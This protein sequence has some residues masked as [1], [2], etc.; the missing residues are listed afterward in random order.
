M[1]TTGNIIGN[2]ISTLSQTAFNSLNPYNQIKLAGTTI[3]GIASTA[4]DLLNPYQQIR[5]VSNGVSAIYSAVTSAPPK[6]S[7][8]PSGNTKFAYNS[9]CDAMNSQEQQYVKE[10]KFQIANT[11]DIIFVPASLAASSVTNKGPTD[12][13]Q[14][15][16]QQSNTAVS[17]IQPSSNS[18]NTQAKNISATQGTQI[19]QFIE[20]TVRN[21]SYITDQQLASLDVLNPDAPIIPNTSN[22]GSGPTTWFKILSTATPIGNKVDTKRNDYAY[23]IKYYVT[24][25][26]INEMNSDY[27]PP[28]KFRGIHKVYN[29]WFTGL[30]TQVLHFEQN[31]NSVYT[32]VAGQ[33]DLA[34][35]IHLLQS[36][37][38]E[39]SNKIG[40]PNS[41]GP[42]IKTSNGPNQS[43]QQAKN[44][45]NTPAA[46]A[47]DFLYS[48]GDQ[49]QID[50]RIVGDPAWLL[51]GELLGITEES[52]SNA[53]AWWPDGTICTEKQEAVFAVNF[54]TPADYNA[55][56]SGPASGT[57]L[58]DINSYATQGNSN[59]L[60]KVSAQSSSAYK[61]TK[62]ISSFNRG[63]FEQTL[64]G[65][66]IKNLNALE[67]DKFTAPPKSKTS[68]S[69][70][71]SRM[72]MAF[73]EGPGGAAFGNPLAARRG[74]KYGAIQDSVNV[75]PNSATPVLNLNTQPASNPTP[76]ES[77]GVVLGSNIPS[78]GPPTAGSTKTTSTF[79]A[80]ELYVPGEPLSQK[81][82]AVARLAVSM[83]NKY[84]PDVMSQLNNQNGANP[85][86]MAP[87]DQ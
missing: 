5:N 30:N 35:G 3:A 11:Y 86:Q 46:T 7:A 69:D 64:T 57:G 37:P 47:A 60:S 79:I 67:I 8:A 83:G 14:T 54:N 68:A 18:V 32:V 84:P 20:M 15:T 33:S 48:A 4:V 44:D 22:K 61:A 26:S 38:T 63:K 6:V 36:P 27:F 82:I 78:S 1:A 49:N 34:A 39:L 81:Q 72:P 85:Q 23:N 70:T 66:R 56:E 55:G 59:N 71:K 62:V 17:A 25:F 42:Q 29:Y 28:A 24:P 40:D 19:I 31:F 65:T 74:I 43:T 87:K 77:E 12:K 21:S 53:S 58:M 45:A 52:L 75:P 2:A 51:Q 13:T 80:G 50:I 16:M 41:L 10:G 73:E 76:P 9:L